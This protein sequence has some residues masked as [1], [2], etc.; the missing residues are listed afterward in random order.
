MYM[1]MV[2]QGRKMIVTTYKFQD[3][4]CNFLKMLFYVISG[5]SGIH[6]PEPELLGTRIV[7]SYIL[8]G[9]FGCHFLEPEILIFSPNFPS[10]NFH[11][12]PN[13]QS[14][15]YGHTVAYVGILSL[16]VHAKIKNNPYLA[17]YLAKINLSTSI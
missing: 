8:R 15:R 14:D 13:A 17:F 5:Y 1:Y 16:G 4:I 9:I 6:D 2:I 10:W 3:F 12:F 7:G 11:D